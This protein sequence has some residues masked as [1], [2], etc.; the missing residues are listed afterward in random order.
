MNDIDLRERKESEREK[1]GQ[2]LQEL[3]KDAEDLSEAQE[4]LTPK[5]GED[6]PSTSRSVEDEWQTIQRLESKILRMQSGIDVLKK[7]ED[8]KDFWSQVTVPASPEIAPRGGTARSEDLSERTVSFADVSEDEPSTSWSPILKKNIKIPGIMKTAA[9]AEE[10][11]SLSLDDSDTDVEMPSLEDLK[12]KRQALQRQRPGSAP[13]ARPSPALSADSTLE[14]KKD[15]WKPIIT[16]PKPFSFLERDEERSKTKPI[17]TVK[18]EQDLLIKDI[19]TA[20]KRKAFKFKA[21]PIPKSVLEA[22]YQNMIKEQET[23]RIMKH[24]AHKKKQENMQNPFAFDLVDK[25][26]QEIKQKKIREAQEAKM[27]VKAFRA[28]AVPAS[29]Y[30]PRY[31]LLQMEKQRRSGK[32]EERARKLMAESKMPR[33]MEIGLEDFSPIP[34]AKGSKVLKSP[35]KRPKTASTDVPDYKKL[36]QEFE[37]RLSQAKANNLLKRT[38]VREFSLSGG[39]RR[40]R[41]RPTKRE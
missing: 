7:S 9:S 37:E 31:E 16:L 33:R 32:I 3:E 27:K 15:E 13:P 17:S 14:A 1:R 34:R 4:S 6:G 23:M 22:R 20:G 26:R 41:P 29:T 5:R 39:G 30:E 24:E 2:M 21:K 40:R 10:D 35:Q 38:I 19:D 11:V 12:G 8:F 25:K 18:M 28:N 36:H